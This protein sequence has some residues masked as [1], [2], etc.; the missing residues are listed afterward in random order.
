MQV[1]VSAPESR[2][3]RLT[4]AERRQLDELERNLLAEYPDL[5]GGFHPGRPH[6]LERRK[7]YAVFLAVAIVLV[8]VGAAVGAVAGALAVVVSLAG[9]TGM[10][11]FVNRNLA[12]ARAAVEAHA[13][14][15]A[16]RKAS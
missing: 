12:H 1:G 9:T 14:R 6:T 3:P 11:C 10:L 13:H 8:V 16:G 15:P 2:P 4:D 7:A 5:K